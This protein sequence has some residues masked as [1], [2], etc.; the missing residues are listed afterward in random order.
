MAIRAFGA[1]TLLLAGCAPSLFK[2]ELASARPVDLDRLARA[3]KGTYLV[4]GYLIHEHICRCP[5]N[6]PCAACPPDF[7]IVG[8]RPR[9][10]RAGCGDWQCS[11][12]GEVVIDTMRPLSPRP[13]PDVACRYIVRLHQISPDMFN[14][15]L[16]RQLVGWECP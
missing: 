1:L 9:T 13:R 3:E 2:Q 7:I 11:E 5:P 16:E 14:R 10:Y 8:P 6:T 12:K 15:S 4:Q